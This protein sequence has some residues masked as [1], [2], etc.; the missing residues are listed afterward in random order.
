MPNN[1]ELSASIQVI[2]RSAFKLYASRPDSRRNLE[3]PE[4]AL[5]FLI[6]PRVYDFAENPANVQPRI[7]FLARNDIH[8][9]IVERRDEPL[10]DLEQ[11]K[12]Y[13]ASFEQRVKA[14]TKGKKF[15]LPEKADYFHLQY[16]DD[17]YQGVLGLNDFV[18]YST[19]LDVLPHGNLYVD[20]YRDRPEL[21]R[22]GIGS[23]FYA[24]LREVAGDLGFRF[25][26][27]HN[28]EE[29]VE[30]NNTF[31]TKKLGRKRFDQLPERVKDLLKDEA[32]LE[33][34][35]FTVD[36]LDYRDLV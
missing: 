8:F 14:L 10:T 6:A 2:D 17:V 18:F 4:S 26:S 19:M 32:D 25:I 11:L 22:K 35:V 23:S 24:R 36:C 34:G 31:F 13:D 3:I 16:S 33:T 20:S 12:K 27:G 30:T 28:E 21:R 15:P 7:A 9:Y 5:R 29:S 1:A